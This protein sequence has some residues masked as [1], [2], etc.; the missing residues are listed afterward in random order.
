MKKLILI[1]ALVA[2]QAPSAFGVVAGGKPVR[3]VSTYSIIARDPVT[4]ELGVAVQS[5]WFS[6]GSVVPW[7]EAGVG[8]VATQS[9]TE[10][11]YGPLGLALMRAGKTANQTLE[12]LLRADENPQWRQVGMIDAAGNRAVHTGQK[13]IREAGHVSGDNF[14]VMANLMQHDTVWE[15]MAKAFR[16]TNAVDLTDRMLNALEAAQT[17]GGDIRGRQSA[18]IVVV[19][20][21]PTGASYRDKLI[22]LRVEDHPQP[23]SE[24]RRLVTLNRAYNAM[25]LGDERL[26]LRDVDGALEAYQSALELAPEVVEIEFWVSVTLF[27]AGYEDDALAHFK[28][29]FEKERIW[30]EVVRRLPR[31]DLLLNDNGQVE[32]ILS[33]MAQPP[34]SSGQ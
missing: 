12:A 27:S 19:T 4:G 3:P 23:V 16:D 26:A 10:V 34:D 30:M 33:V 21:T 24:L 11:T 22:D 1:L 7:V 8:A 13:C 25:N 14:I 6:V 32:R 5:H 15:A 18:A 29:V 9:L 31:A 28:R 20:G 2:V 17:H